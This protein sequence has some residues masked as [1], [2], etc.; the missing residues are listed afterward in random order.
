MKLKNTPWK[1]EE[2]DDRYYSQIEFDGW[3]Y[4]CIWLEV[5]P[6][7]NVYGWEV[8]FEK[9]ETDGL[10]PDFESAK[11]AAENCVIELLKMAIDES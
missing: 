5:Y 11:K 9:T 4:S 10:E 6:R 3:F 7:S 1:K 2:G 8:S